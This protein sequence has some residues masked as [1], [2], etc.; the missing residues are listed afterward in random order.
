MYRAMMND[1][2]QS[3]SV[4]CRKRRTTKRL[5]RDTPIVSQYGGAGRLH[6]CIVPT[7]Y[8]ISLGRDIIFQ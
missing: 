8:H 5:R 7:D 4:D 2:H 3:N 1:G 6:P